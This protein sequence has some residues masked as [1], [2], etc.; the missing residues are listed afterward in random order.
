MGRPRVFVARLQLVITIITL[1]ALLSACAE[2]DA[3]PAPLGGDATSHSERTGADEFDLVSLSA[4]PGHGGETVRVQAHVILIDGEWHLCPFLNESLPP[5]CE[6]PGPRLEGFPRQD[7]ALESSQGV[8]WTSY[9][10]TL[11][12]TFN[13]STSTF[14]VRD[15]K[16]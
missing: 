5:S 10:V 8:S 4:L 12:G 6:G 15:L 11:T 7:S 9:P 3:D 14:E 16:H 1:A 2:P 13:A